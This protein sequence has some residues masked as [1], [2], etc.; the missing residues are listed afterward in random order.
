MTLLAHREP[1]TG[2][3]S[4]PARLMPMHAFLAA[5]LVSVAVGAPVPHLDWVATADHGGGDVVVDLALQPDGR[6]LAVGGGNFVVNLDRFLPDGT[7][8]Y[9]FGTYGSVGADFD[10][11]SFS[12]D[13]AAVAVR[14]DGRI[15]VAAS[16]VHD[17]L[18]AP[19]VAT[20][21]PDGTLS[22]VVEPDLGAAINARVADMILL[23]GGAVLLAIESG[24]FDGSL[25]VALVKLRPDGTLD[26]AFGTG[27]LVRINL[28]P[29][30]FDF[31]S[32]IAVAPDG[33]ILLAGGTGDYDGHAEA[34]PE[35]LLVRFTGAG[36]LDTS[37]GTGGRVTRD[38]TPE[39]MDS[40][41]GLAVAPNGRIV[42]TVGLREDDT[43]F[44]SGLLAYLPNGRPDRTFGRAGFAPGPGPG[45]S[46]TVPIIRPNGR[47]LV[48]GSVNSGTG[49]DLLL[50][51]YL[52]NGQPD[53]AFGRVRTDVNGGN[54]QGNA[55]K[56]QPNGGIVAAG[57]AG[58][59]G[60]TSFGVFR[61]RSS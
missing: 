50:T 39:G 6:I 38:L 34:W 1:I 40:A 31:V 32:S 13:P 15:L 24:T 23:P 3:W 5:V 2:P 56:L 41:Q 44:G 59:P 26:P 7:P 36:A 12:E 49:S 29:R 30:E 4:G 9:T 48:T 46:L 17:G 54:E 55:L 21:L 45:T 8:D 28:G 37:F 19:A 27:G 11:D 22:T 47:I 18:Y 20:Y 61:Y 14:P 25:P 43:T 10:P 57:N 58:S 42:L 52:T 53:R 51:Q 16:V 33:D 35:T 60:D